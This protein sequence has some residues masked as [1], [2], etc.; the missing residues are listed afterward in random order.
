MIPVSQR[1]SEA[2]HQYGLALRLITDGDLT[3]AVRLLEDI[4]ARFPAY[5]KA[6]VELGKIVLDRLE[7]PDGAIDFFR[8]AIE[9]DPA[10]FAAYHGYADSLF[11]LER[12]A[13]MN[14]V[15][16]QLLEIKG[17]PKDEALLRKAKLLESQSRFDESVTTYRQA[18]LA[19]FSLAMIKQCEEGMER[20]RIKKQMLR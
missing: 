6:W 14:A 11:R 7:D 1:V 4:T 20:C 19:S 13:E 9:A 3:G 15:L 16:N 17:A 2:D 5:A 10:C 12:F 18:V 8:K